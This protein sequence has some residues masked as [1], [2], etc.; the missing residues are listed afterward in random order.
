M[1]TFFKLLTVI[2][3]GLSLSCSTEKKGH[4]RFTSGYGISDYSHI[5]ETT[6]KDSIGTL[7]RKL[8]Q[9]VGSQIGILIVDSLAGE[10]IED[11]SLRMAREFGLGRSTHN[12]G[13]LITVVMHE[14][15]IR[16]EVGAGLEN[17]IKDE[18]A[19]GIIR[20]DMTP[21]FK[22][23]KYGQGIYLA[24]DKISNLIVENEKLVGSEPTERD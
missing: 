23:E 12:D 3:I 21:L 14:R 7:I 5:L 1:R 24:V 15:L 13:I 8:E 9:E 4:T 19:A 10:K 11:F 18:V 16:I 2:L 6:A 17:I 22:R 20:D